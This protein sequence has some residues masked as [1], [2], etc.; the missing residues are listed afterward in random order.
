MSQSRSRP[1]P[2]VVIKSTAGGEAAIHWRL[3]CNLQ[4]TTCTP[5]V[6]IDMTN[7]IGRRF[8]QYEIT[9]VIGSGGMGEVYLAQDVRLNRQVAVK[10]LTLEAAQNPELVERFRREAIAASGLDHPNIIDV[11]DL[12]V[13][14]GL[15]YI[16]MRYVDGLTLSEALQQDGPFPPRRMLRVMEQLTDALA[17][18]HRRQII[19]RDIKPANVMLERD[20]FV[21]LTDFGIAY[22][23]SPE[24]LTQIGQ[25]MG[26]AGY[27][28]PEQVS[29]LTVD[30]R[31]DIYALGVLIEEM[32]VGRRPNFGQPPASTLPAAVRKVLTRSRAG[33]ARERYD[34]ARALHDDLQQAVASAP[35]QSPPDPPAADVAA[36][37]SLKLVLKDERKEAREEAREYALRQGHP[38]RLGRAADNDVVLR[39]K[40]VSRHHAEI[41]TDRRGSVL[42]DL[43]ST[44]GTFVNDEQLTPHQPYPI[45]EGV[46]I[47]VG[48]NVRAKIV[49]GAVDQKVED[50]LSPETR[51]RAV[52]Q[53]ASSKQ[54][55]QVDGG[56]APPP[57]PA[58]ARP[59][60]QSEHR[61]LW[62]VGGGI[63]LLIILALACIAWTLFSLLSSAADP[64]LT[65]TSVTVNALTATPTAML[66]VSVTASVTAMMTNTPSSTALGPAVEATD[67]PAVTAR[68]S[69]CPGAPPQRVQVG[70]RA[71]VCTAYDRLIVRAKPLSSSAE[72]T[73][74]DPGTVVDV[75]GGPVCAEDWSWWQIETAAGLTGWVAEGGDEVDPYFICPVR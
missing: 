30:H 4:L 27:M 72:I 18:A 13:E 61:W 3:T 6:F 8:G 17:Y 71:Q 1:C 38:L 68:P 11:Y 36:E 75:A 53:T 62:W 45:A 67:E 42:I 46:R 19:H 48:K 5:E 16:A 24:K 33:Q 35:M 56:Y 28:S 12:G 51:Q 59:G 9:G 31:T 47:R 29:G 64:T 10:I 65:L 39:D 37:R 73:R 66:T 41:H 52:L 74:L 55:P 7:L 43:G 40:R 26:T 63:V 22:A 50:H 2:R 54:L 57:P 70:A 20:D 21:T 25:V 44:N 60:K 69:S 23:P 58:P 34:S 49:R 32:L 14:T 15:Y